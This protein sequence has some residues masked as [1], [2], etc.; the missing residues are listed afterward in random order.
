[1]VQDLVLKFLSEMC[2][3]VSKN[4]VET[5]D[6][7]RIRHAF[8]MNRIGEKL[9]N[10]VKSDEFSRRTESMKD[11]LILIRNLSLAGRPSSRSLS[12]L[13]IWKL[14]QSA[15]SQNCRCNG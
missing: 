14:Q 4:G 12:E 6:A 15:N 3:D 13:P 8:M 10:L 5:Y 9:F 11:A 2:S 7:K 1:M